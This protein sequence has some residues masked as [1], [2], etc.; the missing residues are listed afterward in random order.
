MATK[1]KILTGHRRSLIF[2]IVYG[3][4]WLLCCNKEL[5]TLQGACQVLTHLMEN[6]IIKIVSEIDMRR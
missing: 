6:K 3:L 1:M 4:R 5:I 2:S